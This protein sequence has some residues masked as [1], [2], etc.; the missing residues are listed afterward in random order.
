MTNA[1]ALS[2][3]EKL[4]QLEKKQGLIAYFIFVQALVAT[5]GS[6]YYSTFGDPVKNL[7]ARSLFPTDSGLL[8]CEL[9]W[10][11]RILMY[12]IVILSL[13][14]MLKEDRRFT[15]YILP[16]STLGIFLDIFHYGLQKFNFANPFGCTLSNPCNALQVQYLGF[17]TIPFLALVAFIVITVLCVMNLRINRQVDILQS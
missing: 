12:P 6:L 7:M 9:C 2:S 16:L 10:F 1:S 8:P 15:D 3:Q 4:S 14:G 13:V 11:A 17:I 5:L